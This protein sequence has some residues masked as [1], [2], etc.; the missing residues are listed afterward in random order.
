M[1]QSVII[2]F[3]I[4]GVGF[5]LLIFSERVEV[6]LEDL[7]FDIKSNKF[8]AL[9]I[10]SA[11]LLTILFCW[12]EWKDI[13]LSKKIKY[14]KVGAYFTALGFLATAYSIYLL[15]TQI[16]IQQIA[17]ET[18]NRPELRPDNYSF[19]FLIDLSKGYDAVEKEV[20]IGFK[21]D[22]NE[23]AYDLNFHWNYVED[24]P[25]PGTTNELYSNLIEEK[26]FHRHLSAGKSIEIVLPYKIY[27]ALCKATPPKSDDDFR[28][29]R[30]LYLHITYYSYKR[31][32]AY[33]F[34]TGTN[35]TFQDNSCMFQGDFF[36]F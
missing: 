17:F 32:N 9:V 21:N 20:R 14:E 36:D 12:Q 34:T 35:L 24:T 29:R 4:I 27:N 6:F 7:M 19:S 1:D 10:G 16:R 28:D 2:L 26:I 25:V 30:G 3:V 31:V 22:G 13:D 15:Y 18:E 33:N 5:L 8:S 23:T 11:M